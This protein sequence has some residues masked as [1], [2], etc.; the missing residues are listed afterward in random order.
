MLAGVLEIGKTAGQD[1][2]FYKEQAMHGKGN[3][4]I[5]NRR[6]DNYGIQ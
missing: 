1:V 6:D 4:Q 3:C 2:L 5:V